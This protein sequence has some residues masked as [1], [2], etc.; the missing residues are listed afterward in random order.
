MPRALYV[1]GY[2]LR[3]KDYEKMYDVWVACKNADIEPPEKVR[4]YFDTPIP[5]PYDSTIDIA[6]EVYTDG[7]CEVVRILVSNIPSYLYAIEI[8]TSY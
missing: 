8:R 1:I 6:R 7:D 2:P 5:I 4:D 3:K